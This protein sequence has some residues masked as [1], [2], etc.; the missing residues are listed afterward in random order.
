MARNACRSS[1]WDSREFQIS[2][3]EIERD[4]ETL[5]PSDFK[6]IC[7]VFGRGEFNGYLGIFSTH[8]GIS[9]ELLDHMRLIRQNPGEAV[10]SDLLTTGTTDVGSEGANRVIKTVARDAYGFRDPV[11]QSIRTRCAITRR[12]PVGASS[13]ANFVEPAPAI[14]LAGGAELS[15][16]VVSAWL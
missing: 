6:E 10:T 7:E 15:V 12:E 13:P 14:V 8:E 9:L 4:L 3:S 2:W 11:N 5:F 1:N 16:T